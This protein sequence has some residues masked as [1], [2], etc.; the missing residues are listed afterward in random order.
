MAYV[1]WGKGFKAGGWTTRLS[2]VIPTPKDAEFGPEES[3]T[4][5]LGVKSA[6]LEHHL[7]VN[8]AVYYTDYDGIQLDIQQ[9]I[10]PTYVNAGN[11]KIKGAEL[12][13]QSIV[14]HRAAAQR[15]RVVYRC[16]LHL[17]K[18]EREHSRVRSA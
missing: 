3:K 1:S 13:F 15:L 2:A 9:G 17:R 4:W 18:P 5:E 6:W 10:S 12:Q 16:V 8:A 14:G 7:Q 11:A